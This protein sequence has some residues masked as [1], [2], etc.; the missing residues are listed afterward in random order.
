LIHKAL[1]RVCLPT[2]DNENVWSG[3]GTAREKRGREDKAPAK[4]SQPLLVFVLVIGHIEKPT[5]NG[6]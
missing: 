3:R 4:A 5:K 1:C 2:T 6:S